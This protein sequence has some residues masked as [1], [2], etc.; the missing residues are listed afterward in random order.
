MTLGKICCNIVRYF[1]LKKL[2]LV[3]V[4]PDYFSGYCS[5]SGWF[6]HRSCWCEIFF[7]LTNNAKG[8][9]CRNKNRIKTEIESKHKIRVLCNDSYVILTVNCLVD[10]RML[11]WQYC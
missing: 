5:R 8:K 2:V 9:I 6:L 11:R 1:V 7:M 4:E 3:F 10:T